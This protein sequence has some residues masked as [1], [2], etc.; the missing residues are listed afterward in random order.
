MSHSV[1]F[2]FHDVI[3]APSVNRVIDFTNRALGEQNPQKICYLISSGGGSV[4]SGV[5]LYNYLRALP[6]TVVMHNVGSVDSIANAVFLAGQE[7]YA[8]PASAFLL[9]GVMWNFHEKSTLSYPQMQEIMSR[10]DAAEQLIARIIGENTKLT[11]EEVR[12]LFRQGESK[13]P[14]FAKEKGMIHDIREVKIEAGSPIIAI[15]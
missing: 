1:Y 6:V 3:E 7:R 11:T 9:H 10:F 2:T 5:T 14:Q 12:A 13:T 15:K 8:M 4:D